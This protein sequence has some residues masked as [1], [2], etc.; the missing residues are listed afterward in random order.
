[1][2]KYT[3]NYEHIVNAAYNRAPSRIPIYEHMI[4][5]E[6]MEEILGIKFFDY[7][8]GNDL[9]LHEY[10]KQYNGF[11]H[12]MTYDTISFECIFSDIMPGNG[13]LY[14]HEPG[15]IK[16]YDDIKKYPWDDLP[17]L[18]FKQN[19]RYFDIATQ[20]IPDGMSLIGGIGNGVFEC[21][22]D[23]VGYT[24]LCY[25]KVDDPEAY[26]ILFSKMGD[27]LLKTWEMFIPLYKDN[28]CVFRFGDDLGYKSNT[29]LPPDDVV[30]YIFPQYKKTIDLVHSYNKPFLLHSCGNLFEVMDSLID[31]GIN[32]KHSNEDQIAPINVWY[33]KYGEKIGNFGGIDADML[34]RMNKD[35]L[36]NYIKD[37]YK[38]S[39]NAKGVALGSGN[40]IPEYI[41]VEN[42]LTMIETLNECRIKD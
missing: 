21:I 3:P 32:A 7:Y 40:S 8:N 4:S 23:I 12:E 6:I 35:E 27:I 17:T 2:E 24:N 9:D 33:E 14:G 31:T 39:L 42:Y 20:H 41:P 36:R 38:Q 16:N 30:K 22:Q 11:F 10:F 28:F 5:E 34:C 25:L 1:M 18:F 26:S 13:A 15:C 19:K 29:L 37:I